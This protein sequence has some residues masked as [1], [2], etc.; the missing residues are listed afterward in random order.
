M[1]KNI[2][3]TLTTFAL[4]TFIA[5][6]DRPECENTNLIFEKYSPELKEY[7]D[8]LVNQLAKVDRSKLT[9]WI[10]S[11]Q[12]DKNSKYIYS[13]IQGDGLCAKIVLEIYD[14]EKG[15]KGIIKN[16]GKGYQGAELEN[17]KF[18]IRQDSTSTNFIFQE[19]D[20]IID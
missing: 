13:H 1:K 3:R 2:I 20:G 11:Y 18:D 10:D 12:E 4:L 5:S 8:E 19:I 6:C 15:I 16:K 9:Y 17:L 7:K 14:S